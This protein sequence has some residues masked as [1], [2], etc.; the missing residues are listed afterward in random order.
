MFDQNLK[1]YTLHPTPHTLHSTPC[2][3]V[4]ARLLIIPASYQISSSLGVPSAAPCSQSSSGFCKRFRAFFTVR[5]P[6]SVERRMGKKTAGNFLDDFE[7]KSRAAMTEMPAAADKLPIFTLSAG[8]WRISP[9]RLYSRVLE[10][11]VPPTECEW[12]GGTWQ[13]GR[14]TPVSFLVQ[15]HPWRG[16]RAVMP[17]TVIAREVEL[18]LRH[19]SCDFCENLP[20]ISPS[21]VGATPISMPLVPLTASRRPH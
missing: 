11:S 15:N 12:M 17:R 19:I 6:T 21:A 16:Q 4:R 7:A 3:L 10:N 18:V 9:C 13:A 2:T 1:P 14:H 5:A 20:A 8:G